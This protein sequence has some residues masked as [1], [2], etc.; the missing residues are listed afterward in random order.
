[1]IFTGNIYIASVDQNPNWCKIGFTR[2]RPEDRVSELKR[3]YK[4]Y[5]FSLFWSLEVTN[6]SQ[7]ESMLKRFFQ[8]R[9]VHGE[10]FSVSPQEALDAANYIGERNFFVPWPSFVASMCSHSPLCE[11]SNNYFFYLCMEN[12]GRF[13]HVARRYFDLF[14]IKKFK[15]VDIEHFAEYT[16]EHMK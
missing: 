7:R 12:K 8:D 5:T 16:M 1:M 4:G 10:M 15:D 6:P 9:V 11:P 13:L 2:K 3:C 14:D